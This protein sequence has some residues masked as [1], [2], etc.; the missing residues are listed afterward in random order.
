MEP[1]DREVPKKRIVN[2][3]INIANKVKN[4]T[5]N[6]LKKEKVPKRSI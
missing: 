5:V 6:H 4:D 1:S 3:Y 2:Y